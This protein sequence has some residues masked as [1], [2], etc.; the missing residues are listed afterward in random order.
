MVEGGTHN[1]LAPVYNFLADVFMPQLRTMGVTVECQLDR[2]GF[3]RTGGGQ[4]TL[5]VEPV[6]ADQQPPEYA[7]FERGALIKREAIVHQSLLPHDIV[8][9]EWAK[10]A[11]KL[12]YRQTELRERFI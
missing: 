10:V 5:S 1:P 4:I 8:E 7:L 12:G 2:A 3:M 9:R 6:S 11:K